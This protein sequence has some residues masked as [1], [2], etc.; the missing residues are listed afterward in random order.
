[1]STSTRHGLVKPGYGDPAD[2]TVINDNMDKIE[3]LLDL[4]ANLTDMT[5]PFNFKGS[6]TYANLPSSSNQQNDTW[7]VTDKK[8]RYTWTGS[9]WKQSSMDEGD[10][11]DE[12]ST[13][14]DRLDA[15][16]LYVDSDGDICQGE[17]ES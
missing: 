14:T 1:M 5:T 8:C 4:K 17:E 13:L 9:A 3:D 6:C 10:Y 7:Y 15:L 11:E 16:G 12:L 2:I